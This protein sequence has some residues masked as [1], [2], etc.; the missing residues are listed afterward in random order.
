MKILG[1]DIGTKRIG[2][3]VSDELEIAA[4]A[5]Y[6]INRSGDK[7]TLG[8]IVDII[9]AEKIAKI[10][11]GYPVNMNGTRGDRARDSEKIPSG[12]SVI[13]TRYFMG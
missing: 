6:F 2:V 5:R 4:H 9:K 10:V 7:E 8:R 13:N 12:K 3:A 1:L 11:I